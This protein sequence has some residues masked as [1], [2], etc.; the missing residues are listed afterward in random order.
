M[1]GR[2]ELKQ[3]EQLIKKGEVDTVLAV[4]PLA[5]ELARLPAVVLAHGTRASTRVDEGARLLGDA[6]ARVVAAAPRPA[7]TGG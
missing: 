2:L 4:F 1:P 7:T 5:V 6:R 3:L